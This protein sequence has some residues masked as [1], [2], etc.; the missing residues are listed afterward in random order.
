MG[1]TFRDAENDG[2]TGEWKVVTIDGADICLQRQGPELNPQIQVRAE[3]IERH[4]VE[5]SLTP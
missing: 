4:M 1:R 3:D 2:K 5:V